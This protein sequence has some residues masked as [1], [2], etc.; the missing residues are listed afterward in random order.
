MGETAARTLLSQLERSDDA[1]STNGA[2]PSSVLIAPDL[3][4]RGTTAPARRS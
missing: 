4:V 2:A 1:A 3:V